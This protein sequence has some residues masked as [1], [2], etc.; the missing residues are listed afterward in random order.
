MIASKEEKVNWR[1]EWGNEKTKILEREKWILRLW[2]WMIEELFTLTIKF[3]MLSLS[4]CLPSAVN[5]EKN[6]LRE[7]RRW[8]GVSC[9]FLKKAGM[10]SQIK[11]NSWDLEFFWLLFVFSSN[12]LLFMYSSNKVFYFSK[13]TNLH[14]LTLHLYGYKRLLWPTLR[15]IA[16]IRA[17]GG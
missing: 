7:E 13:V 11:E 12:K 3:L 16:I 1:D 4:Q 9:K 8:W 17:I 5:R 2:L 14:Y 10:I 15:S 6:Y